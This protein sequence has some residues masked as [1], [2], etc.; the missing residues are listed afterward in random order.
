MPNKELEGAVKS[1]IFYGRWE[2]SQGKSI[3]YK[4]VIIRIGKQRLKVWPK[5]TEKLW[6]ALAGDK[7][8]ITIEKDD[9]Q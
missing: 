9:R 2:P 6:T 4:E 1:N 3:F 5:P 8:K 7:I